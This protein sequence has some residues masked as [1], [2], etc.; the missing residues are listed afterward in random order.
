MIKTLEI[1]LRESNVDDVVQ[2]LRGLV[3][4]VGRTVNVP[5]LA[6]VWT[7]ASGGEVAAQNG[8][9][10]GSGLKRRELE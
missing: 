2:M 3:L 5:A 4:V 9:V 1:Q 8:L 10:I 7:G 6:A